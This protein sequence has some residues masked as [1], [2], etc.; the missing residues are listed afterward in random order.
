MKTNI[1]L[2]K[3]ITLNL[4]IGL[5]F[6]AQGQAT[7]TTSTLAGSGSSGSSNGTG[8]G[9]TFNTPTDVQIGPD[10]N[11]YIAELSGQKIRKITPAGVVTTFAG[12]TSGFANG[13]GTAAKFN[14]PHNIVFDKSGNMFVT[15]YGNHKIRKITPAGVVTTFAGSTPG[16]ANGTGTAAKFNNPFAMCIDTF[17]NLYV[18]DWRNYRIRKITPAGVVTTFAGSGQDA[19]ANGTGTAAKFQFLSG[20]TCDK[21]G[22]IYTASYVNNCIRKITPAGVVTTYAGVKGSSSHVNGTL[23]AIRFKSPSGL[24]I[25]AA[26]T[27][28]ITDE[29]DHRIRMIRNGQSYTLGGNGTGSFANGSQSVSRFKYPRSIV[30]DEAGNLY[31]CDYGNQRIRK[32][33]IPACTANSALPT[34]ANTTYTSHFRGI[35]SNWTITVLRTVNYFCR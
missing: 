28:F 10:G 30:H 20:M 12:S 32:I 15:D 24:S 13:T 2:F 3:I 17:D 7:Y 14:S 25:D 23:S 35:D 26:G 29:S 33:A 16:Y 34:S 6:C 8:A 27:M 21:E 19:F 31:L 18:F 11:V 1:T 4:A 9:A 5:G 22:N